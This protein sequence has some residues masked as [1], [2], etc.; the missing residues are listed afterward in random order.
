MQPEG[1]EAVL[2]HVTLESTSERSLVTDDGG[3]RER[4]HPEEVARI[5]ETIR[6]AVSTGAP[7]GSC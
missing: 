7:G 5:D 4:I 1:D 2:G 6:M 3:W